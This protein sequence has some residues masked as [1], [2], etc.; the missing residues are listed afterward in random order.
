VICSFCKDNFD[1]FLHTLM[2][3]RENRNICDYSPPS[4]SRS[5]TQKAI[6]VLQVVR[7]VGSSSHVEMS[8][9]LFAEDIKEHGGVDRILSNSLDRA[10]QVSELYN[11][12]KR[13]RTG[14]TDNTDTPPSKL[15]KPGERLVSSTC[16][17]NAGSAT[18]QPSP[19]IERNSGDPEGEGLATSICSSCGNK[20]TCSSCSET[21]GRRGSTSKTSVQPVEPPIKP[22][23]KPF[24]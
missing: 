11:D 19:G 22:D 20:V 13:K 2:C 8:S 4:P 24:S 17:P 15:P 16:G 21:G 1:S 14:D 23:G 12:N 3:V 6:P 10:R 7:A 5:S 9:N 18:P